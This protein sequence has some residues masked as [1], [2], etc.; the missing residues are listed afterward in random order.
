[1]ETK[2]WRWRS[3][4][5]TALLGV[6]LSVACTDT[7][8]PAPAPLPQTLVIYNFSY[9]GPHTCQGY[10]ANWFN[11]P[12]AGTLQVTARWQPLHF[13]FDL[14]VNTKPEHQEVGANRSR[15]DGGLASVTVAV[16][17]ARAYD[18]ELRYVSGC[19]EVANAIVEVVFTPKS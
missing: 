19:P 16:P 8:P 9:G 13:D 5:R 18:Y 6:W 3:P 17:A 4:R 10:Q 7:P 1:M 2:L 12:G 11:V 14:V 15:S